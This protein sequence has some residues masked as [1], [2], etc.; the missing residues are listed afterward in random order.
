MNQLATH[1]FTIKA[2]DKLG[3]SWTHFT[4][5]SPPWRAYTTDANAINW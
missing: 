3:F 4:R 1:Q 5:C 2:N